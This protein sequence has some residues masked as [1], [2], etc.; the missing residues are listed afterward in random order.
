MAVELQVLQLDWSLVGHGDSRTF[1]PPPVRVVLGADLVYD[2]SSPALLVSVLDNLCEPGGLFVLE[3]YR[4]EQL[5][6]GTGG[7]QNLALMMT[8]AELREELAGLDWLVSEE[9][10]REI[11]EGVYHNGLSRTIQVICRKPSA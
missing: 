8:L 5:G 9:V 2:D 11:H 10:E 4:P 6:L 1:R 3:A 7:P